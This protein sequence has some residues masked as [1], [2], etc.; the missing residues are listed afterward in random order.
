MK[1][2][3]TI[4]IIEQTSKR[5]KEGDFIWKEIETAGDFFSWKQVSEKIKDFGI[6]VNA[7]RLSRLYNRDLVKG[8]TTEF[9]YG[10]N[11]KNGAPQHIKINRL[12]IGK[13]V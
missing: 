3:Y 10:N 9:F 1:Y 11:S 6:N 8:I 2:T 4:L 7:Q 5:D 12:K 13:P